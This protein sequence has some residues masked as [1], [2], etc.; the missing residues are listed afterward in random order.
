MKPTIHSLQS[1]RRGDTPIARRFSNRL[2]K[3]DYQFQPDRSAD[4]AD[5][6]HGGSG[7]SFRGISQEYF[8]NEARGHFVSEAS[9]FV[10]MLFTAAVPVIQGARGAMHI[11]RAYGIL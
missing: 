1:P 2:P 6:C 10:L 7:P 5:R 8:N 9:V 11:L 3:T 4:F